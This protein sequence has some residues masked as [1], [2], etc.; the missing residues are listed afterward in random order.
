VKHLSAAAITLAAIALTATAC[1]SSAKSGT[2]APAAGSTPATSAPSPP[3]GTGSG[4][5]AGTTVGVAHTS[6]GTFLVDGQG[7]TLYLFEKDTGHTSTCDGA[8]AQAWPPAATTGAPHAGAGVNAAL[9]GTTTRADHTVEIT[10]NGH[11]LYTFAG[12]N[13]PGDTNGEGSKAFGAGWYVVT[14]AGAKI[15]N[16]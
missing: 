7:H 9:L 5:A 10:Y 3:A 11:P 14:P 13:K 2:A 6:L 16:S 12:D 4:A 8:C 1:S 15:D